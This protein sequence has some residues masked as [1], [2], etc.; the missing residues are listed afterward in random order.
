MQF[1]F[2]MASRDKYRNYRVLAHLFCTM[3]P[4]GSPIQTFRPNASHCGVLLKSSC[5]KMLISNLQP[6]TWHFLINWLQVVILQSGYFGGISYQK[7][8]FLKQSESLSKW[9]FPRGISYLQY[10]AP[11]PPLFRIDKTGDYPYY[12]TSGLQIFLFTDTI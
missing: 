8:T 6:L 10:G 11:W 4:H 2:T 5:C 12:D 7:E 9:W 3:R 1:Q